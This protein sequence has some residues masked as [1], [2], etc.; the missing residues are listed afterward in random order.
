MYSNGKGERL[1]K[2]MPASKDMNEYRV[3]WKT[4]RMS[5]ALSSGTVSKHIHMSGLMTL[6]PFIQ[7]I[8]SKGKILACILNLCNGY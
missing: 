7:N 2:C 6:V 3:F 1:G 5:L 8:C 4:P